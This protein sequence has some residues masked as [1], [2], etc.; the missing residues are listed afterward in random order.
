M[1]F[2]FMSLPPRTATMP[3]KFMS[4]PPDILDLVF[5]LCDKRTLCRCAVLVRGLLPY[6]RYHIYHKLEISEAFAHLAI[7]KLLANARHLLSTTRK[8]TL[9]NSRG[10]IPLRDRM[11]LLQILLDHH[12]LTYVDYVGQ[13]GNVE[14]EGFNQARERELLVQIGSLPSMR[15]LG[16]SLLLDP[17]TMTTHA[18]ELL[19]V[20]SLR[21]IRLVVAPD[22][23]P[24]QFVDAWGPLPPLERLEFVI[25]REDSSGR[26]PK[27]SLFQDWTPWLSLSTLRHLKFWCSGC[28]LPQFPLVNA[29]ESLDT[30]SRSRSSLQL[31]KFIF[32]LQD[33]REI[34]IQSSELTI[35]EQI[36]NQLIAP[37]ATRASLIFF[38]ETT[39]WINYPSKWISFSY[40]LNTRVDRD[41]IEVHFY[42]D[43][44][45]S[46]N[47]DRAL[48]RMPLDTLSIFTAIYGRSYR[49]FRS[50]FQD[51]QAYERK[52]RAFW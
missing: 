50:G 8:L 35:F 46:P 10:T 40:V 48:D 51:S 31:E 42:D 3:F 4:L 11:Q 47:R 26:R 13:N 38:V 39:S 32:V 9:D 16:L 5:D 24:I 29:L 20:R 36:A 14:P 28:F 25:D 19:L 49:V 12:C 34:K 43:G 7:R 27:A 41:R 45:E 18:L 2:K 21:N 30:R 37:M 44:S 22:A 52:G 33:L 15:W 6:C 17:Y 23:V 1:P